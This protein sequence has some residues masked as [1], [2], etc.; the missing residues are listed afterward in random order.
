[1]AVLERH[2]DLV[3]ELLADVLAVKGYSVLTAE[4]GMQALELIRG[5]EK[6]SVSV[7][8]GTF[9]DQA[10]D[11]A[12]A[13]AGRASLGSDLGCGYFGRFHDDKFDSLLF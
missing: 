8:L 12:S 7:T 13:D 5:K 11:E 9:Q 1:M 6:K 2:Q 4:S 3:D 10:Q